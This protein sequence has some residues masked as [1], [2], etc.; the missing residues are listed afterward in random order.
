MKW[1]GHRPP[2]TGV[3]SGN[4]DVSN[5]AAVSQKEVRVHVRTFVS[6]FLGSY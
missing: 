3:A 6:M 5:A 1:T 2:K 4:A